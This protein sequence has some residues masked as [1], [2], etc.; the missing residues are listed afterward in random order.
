M[1]R[2]LGRQRDERQVT[3]VKLL[4]LER[5][6]C[7]P[8]RELKTMLLARRDAEPIDV[9][10]SDVGVRTDV[11]NVNPSNAVVAQVPDRTC[12]HSTCDQG[13][14][15]PDFVGDQETANRVL[16]VKSIEDVI[17]RRPLEWLE[18]AQNRVHIDAVPG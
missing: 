18:R 15:K 16:A 4:Q 8:R 11:D 2:G 1:K 7:Q 13:L 17:D 14:S 10:A 12:D 3:L 9:L 5:K 6:Q